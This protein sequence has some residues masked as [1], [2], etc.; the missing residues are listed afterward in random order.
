MST[1]PTV[2]EVERL[3]MLLIE[4]R[5]RLARDLHDSVNQKLFSLLLICGE[6]K[7]IY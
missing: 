1:E 7:I 2:S 5:K 4:E 3:K 6:N